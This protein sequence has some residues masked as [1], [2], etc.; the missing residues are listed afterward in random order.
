MF[1]PDSTEQLSII[2]RHLPSSS[3]ELWSLDPIW[4]HWQ[5]SISHPSRTPK[6]LPPTR[7]APLILALSLHTSM[8][9]RAEQN[10]RKTNDSPDLR[11]QP[12]P[13]QP[14]L[15]CRC[16]SASH[17]RIHIHTQTSSVYTHRAFDA[18]LFC[19]SPRSPL[20]PGYTRDTLLS[21]IACYFYI[22]RTP[23]A[24]GRDRDIYREASDNKHIFVSKRWEDGLSTLTSSFLFSVSNPQPSI[25]TFT[26]NFIIIPVSLWVGEGSSNGVLLCPSRV[27]TIRLVCSNYISCLRLRAYLTKA[28]NR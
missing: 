8:R 3:R 28:K 20:H 6:A 1:A 7:I 5:P 11:I 19:E 13:T 10:K 24:G 15:R 4:P 21:V 27:C 12:R 25:R 9:T 16:Y 2:G 18:L 23:L 26:I 22:R 17:M 14:L